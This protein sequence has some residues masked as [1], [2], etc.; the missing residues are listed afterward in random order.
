MPS[1]FLLEKPVEIERDE[2]IFEV[3]EGKHTKRYDLDH[4]LLEKIG[5]VNV[6]NKKNLLLVIFYLIFKIN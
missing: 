1:I 2:I 6:E 3:A 4:D 5:D